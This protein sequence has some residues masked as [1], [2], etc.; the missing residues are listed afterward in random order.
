[1][2]K[3]KPDP[4][5][6]QKVLEW[7][8]SGKNSLIWSKENNI[9]YTTLLGWK[10]R[11]EI[12]HKNDTLKSSTG[13]I[14]LKDQPPT[15]SGVFLEYHGIKICLQPGFNSLVLKQCLSCIKSVPC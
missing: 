3:G 12:A 2:A 9:P 5:W 8:A 10:R 6:K 14:E 15:N 13:F 4:N 11:L 7:K 1:M